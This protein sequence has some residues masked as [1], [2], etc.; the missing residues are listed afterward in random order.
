MSKLKGLDISEW[1]GNVD[2]KKVKAAGIQFLILRDGYAQSV[3]SRFHSYAEGAKKAGIPVLG[4]YHF[5]YALNADQ[6]KKEAEFCVSEAK[7]AGLGKETVIFFDFEYDTVDKAKKQGVILGPMECNTHAK[8]FCDTV[9]K[10]GYKPGIYFNID[11]YKTMYDHDLLSKYTCWLA[12][13]TS[14]DPA[15]KCTFHQYSSTGKVNGISGNVD[16]NYCYETVAS[17]ETPKAGKH[18]ASMVIEI[19]KAEVGY[20]EKASN[21][22][23]DSKT[24]NKGAGNWTKY[25]RDLDAYTD[26]YNG[27]KNGFAWCD[28]FNDWCHY[29]AFGAEVAKKTLCQPAK[30]LGAGCTYS[31]AYYKA[32]GRVGKEPRLG[33]QIFFG[34]KENDL[35][36][37]GL[38]YSFDKEKVYTIE[39][40]TS[41]CVAYRSYPIN[42]S[43][44]WGYGYPKYDDEEV[45]TPVVPVVSEPEE[46]EPAAPTSTPHYAESFSESFNKTYK[47]QASDGLNCRVGPSVENKMINVF[48]NGAIVRCYGYYTKRDNVNWLYVKGT[49]DGRNCVGF[50][51]GEYLIENNE[52]MRTVSATAY[53]TSY[54]ASYAGDYIVQA[55]DGLHCRNNAGTS[56]RSL[57]VFP[58][59]TNVHCYGYYS[60][61]NPGRQVWLYVE[62]VIGSVKYQGFSSAQYLKKK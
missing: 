24:A 13:Y 36:H 29:K 44:I 16:L 35:D 17:T 28:V 33:A 14:G 59:N 51:S 38:V 10:G 20:Y 6:A 3:D 1:Q 2:F 37:T 49:I 12:H 46:D 58:N 30:A 40:N 53:A 27:A 60:V 8:V 31:Y 57:C 45:E 55:S 19:A 42:S 5:S 15:Y 61:A 43:S 22:D 4:I 32:E 11:Y 47:V 7:K 41:D 62:A 18:T 54:N 50:V 23:L 52:P 25:A 39:G 21:K 48:Q 9:E 56:N 34:K 26:F